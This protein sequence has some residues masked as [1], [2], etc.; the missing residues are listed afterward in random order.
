MALVYKTPRKKNHSTADVRK[1]RVRKD[2]VIKRDAFLWK[3]QDKVQLGINL[4]RARTALGLTRTE[5]GKKYGGYKHYNIRRYEKGETLAPCILLINVMR[6][7]YPT[8]LLFDGIR[9]PAHGGLGEFI[10]HAPK[11]ITEIQNT[12]EKLKHE[13]KNA[14]EEMQR[15]LIALI[16]GTEEST[17]VQSRVREI[18]EKY[19][20]INQRVTH[21]VKSIETEKKRQQQY[22][23]HRTKDQSRQA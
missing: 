2:A 22:D 17:K 23:Q 14:T 6:D 10:R 15:A 20:E 1:R 3:E 19:A 4:E 9:K 11:Q 16:A 21:I 18:Y 5:F 8:H 13:L 12:A 7:G